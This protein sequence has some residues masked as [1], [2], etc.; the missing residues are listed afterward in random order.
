MSGTTLAISE[1]VSSLQGEGQYTGYPTTF[2][3][4][5]K[6]NIFCKF[7][8]AKYALK[9]KKKRMSVETIL[10]YIFKMGNE[11]V[12]ITGG[13][14]LL[15]D[16]VFCLIYDLVDRGYHVSIETNGTIPIDESTYHRS[17][18]YDMDIKCPSSGYSDKN[19]YNNLLNLQCD[20]EVKFVITD[21]NDYIFA[22]E[23]LAKYPTVAQKIF[24]PVFDKDNHSNADQLAQ[25]ILEDKIPGVKLGVQIHKLIGIY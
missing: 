25:W 3:R 16:A 1:I 5:Y 19:I 15:Q 17:Y 12:C 6:C 21:Y 20:D 23:I 14:P 4:L 10:E 13:E 24:S 2:V 18:I 11:Y 8:D 7:C 22:K 9:G